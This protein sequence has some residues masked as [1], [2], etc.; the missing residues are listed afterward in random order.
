MTVEESGGR[1]VKS[2]QV[3]KLGL[4]KTLTWFR[5][6]C[7]KLFVVIRQC[8]GGFDVDLTPCGHPGQEGYVSDDEIR[9]VEYHD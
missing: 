8:E 6:N 1:R 2:V 4:T 7:W 3:V 5:D 9:V